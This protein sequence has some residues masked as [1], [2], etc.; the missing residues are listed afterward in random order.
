[1]LEEQLKRQ[2]LYNK[3]LQQ[4]GIIDLEA[5]RTKYRLPQPSP[6]PSL[7]SGVDSTQSSALTEQCST[8]ISHLSSDTSV[9][10]QVPSIVSG[11]PFFPMFILSYYL[12]IHYRLH[13]CALFCRKVLTQ[14]P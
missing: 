7:T 11:P 2:K 13:L 3:Q 6:S 14:F 5:E 12:V 1:M 4:G 8:P 9:A 10:S